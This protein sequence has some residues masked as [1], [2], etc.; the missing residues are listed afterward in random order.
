MTAAKF[1]QIL[2]AQPEVM[3]PP[4]VPDFIIEVVSPTDRRRAIEEKM[5]EWING[6]VTLG[7]LI[8]PF[9]ETVAVYRADGSRE[10]ILNPSTISGEGLHA[11]TRP[12]LG[13]T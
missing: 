4:V 8:D 7:W 3:F 10:T 12:H 6:G 1:R 13:L 2:A 5:A 11:Q 9:K